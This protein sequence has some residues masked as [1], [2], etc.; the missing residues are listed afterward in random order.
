MYDRVNLCDGSAS[1]PRRRKATWT[2]LNLG[3]TKIFLTAQRKLLPFNW[4]VMKVLHSC[5]FAKAYM[6]QYMQSS[7]IGLSGI[8]HIE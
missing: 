1:F 3:I 4:H 2:P 8:I 5:K 7:S 6:W